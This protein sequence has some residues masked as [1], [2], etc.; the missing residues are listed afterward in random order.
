MS[1]DPIRM[2]YRNAYMMGFSTGFMFC[3]AFHAV[4][5][6]WKLLFGGPP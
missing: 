1:S 5:R 2:G 4:L 6:N 3:V